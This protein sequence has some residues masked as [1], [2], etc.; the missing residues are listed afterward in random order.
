MT[1][2][3]KYKKN[4]GSRKVRRDFFVSVHQ[5]YFTKMQFNN[6]FLGAPFL[7]SAAQ[8]AKKRRAI[9]SSP[10]PHISSAASLFGQPSAALR[11]THLYPCRRVQQC[12]KP[13]VS[14][15]HNQLKMRFYQFL[16]NINTM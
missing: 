2:D 5:N 1:D 12:F 6:T 10:Q 16:H 4:P 13:P 9:G 3:S 7:A 15:L 8:A 14:P 11:A